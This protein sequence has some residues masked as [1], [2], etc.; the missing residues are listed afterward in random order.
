MGNSL[1]SQN[2]IFHFVNKLLFD[3]LQGLKSG[4][5]YDVEPVLNFLKMNKVIVVPYMNPDTYTYIQNIIMSDSSE[6]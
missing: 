3:M 4:Y 6:I 1:L 5:P 2:Y